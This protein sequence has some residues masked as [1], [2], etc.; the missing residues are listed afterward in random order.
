MNTE[1]KRFYLSTR[2]KKIGGVCGGIAEYF[3]I[4]SL[5]VRAIFL[6]FLLGY[7]S[8]LLIYLILWAL[9]PKDSAL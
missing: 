3:N 6:F 5:L 2:D 7:G 4:D 8:G 9:A 1:P